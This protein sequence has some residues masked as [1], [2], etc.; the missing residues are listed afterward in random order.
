VSAL[1]LPDGVIEVGAL[2]RTVQDVEVDGRRYRKG[3]SIIIEDYVSAEE[4]LDGVPFYWGSVNGGVYNIWIRADRVELTRSAAEMSAR[5]IPDAEA[6]IKAL[7]SAVMDRFDGF[8]INET[9]IDGPDSLLV[10]GC[11][12][13]GLQFGFTLTV[14]ELQEVEE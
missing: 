9:E 1:E 4:S 11:T 8:E 5:T 6:I 12:G 7:S 14:S 2:A 13:D 3:Q 10:Y